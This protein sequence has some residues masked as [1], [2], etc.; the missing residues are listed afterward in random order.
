MCYHPQ[1]I[2]GVGKVPCG[3]CY[4]CVQSFRSEWMFRN[5]VEVNY[6]NYACFVTLTYDNDVLDTLATDPDDLIHLENPI[7]RT[8]FFKTLRKKINVRYYGCFEYGDK[9]KRPHYH[10]ILYSDDLITEDLLDACWSYGYV[11]FGT[12]TPAS[13]HYVSQYLNKPFR[14][15]RN[16]DEYLKVFYKDDPIKLFVSLQ[17]N[18]IFEST[19]RYMSLRPAIGY[20]LLDDTETVNYIR[21]NALHNLSY[22]SLALGNKTYKLPR[23]Y[24]KKLFSDDERQLIFEN[25]KKLSRNDYV[26]TIKS[27]NISTDYRFDELSYINNKKINTLLDS[28]EKN[29]LF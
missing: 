20:Q 26:N 10:F 3:R 28:Y 1:I 9:F 8:N 5:L 12:C 18:R 11:S 14:R 2:K 24:I 17:N 23:Y 15:Y 6:N 7:H 19:K 22:P 16:S 29:E 21:E 13:I 4:E 25:L 27:R